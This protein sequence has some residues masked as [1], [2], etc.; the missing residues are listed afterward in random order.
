MRPGHGGGGGSQPISAALVLGKAAGPSTAVPRGLARGLGAR[1]RGQRAGGGGQEAAGPGFFRRL[2]ERQALVSVLQEESGE[3]VVA[4][5]LGLPCYRRGKA[6][7]NSSGRSSL[8][9]HGATSWVSECT[10]TAVRLL[11]IP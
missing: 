9:A 10:P 7:R 1:G 6:V 5:L 2:Q 4:F 11:M 3:L 8:S